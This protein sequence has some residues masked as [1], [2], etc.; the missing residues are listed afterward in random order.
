M[1][2]LFGL[3]P[4]GVCRAAAVAGG[5]VGSYSTLSTWPRRGAVDSFLWHFPWGRPRRRLTGTVVPWSPDFPRPAC[6]GR[7]RPTLWRLLYR[8]SALAVQE[9]LEKDRPALAVD[10]SVEQFGA[11]AALEGDHR[12]LLLAN[13]I[14]PALQSEQEAAVGPGR[15]GEVSGRPGNRERGAGGWWGVRGG[16]GAGSRWGGSRAQSNNSPGSSLRAGAT[17]EWPTMF[18]GG[19]W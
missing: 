19:T 6:A 18:A 12:L 15:I 13:V 10:D 1:P 17:S 4:G 5:A 3:A 11:K 9:Q 2:P 8:P 7:G 16:R 14:A